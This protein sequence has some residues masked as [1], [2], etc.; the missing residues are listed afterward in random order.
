MKLRK[1]VLAMALPLMMSSFL[2]AQEG[3]PKPNPQADPAKRHEQL[4]AD[5]K[6]KLALTPAQEVK[7]K[8]LLDERAAEMKAQREAR[9]QAVEA[10]KAER[11][12]KMNQGNEKQQAFNAKMKEILTAEQYVKYLELKQENRG[13][14]RGD[15]QGKGKGEGKPRQN[16]QTP[17]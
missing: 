4:I 2:M 10:Q 11:T 12:E 3:T 9:K 17:Q 16:M 14:M 7:V 6:T 8:A 15:G 5:W 1:L 13:G